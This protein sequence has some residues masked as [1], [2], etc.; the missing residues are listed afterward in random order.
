[1]DKLN[2]S[3]EQD[4][5][6]FAF[7][8][9]QRQ[10]E[11]WAKWLAHELEHYH[12]PVKLNGRK[13]LPNE[14]R[15]I[16][17][18]VDELSAGN[19]PEQIHDALRNSKNLIVIC[20]RKSAK[21]KWVNKEVEEFIKLGKTEHIF[22]FIIDGI[23]HSKNPKTECFPLALKQIPSDKERCG[24]NISESTSS[25]TNPRVCIDCP[26]DSNDKKHGDIK[27]KGRDAAV[28]KIVAGMLNL[29]FDT[30]WER[31]EKEKAEEE[32][33]IRE[34]RDNLLKLQSRFL[35]EKANDETASNR[36]F[37]SRL[38][39]IEALQKAY[40]R[41]AENALRRSFDSRQIKLSGH[42]RPVTNLVFSSDG[43]LLASA[44]EDQSIRIW[45]MKDG[46]CL[47][48]F[49]GHTNAIKS[50]N[51]NH[52]NKLLVSTSYDNTIR[53]WNLVTE[54]Q[55]YIFRKHCKDIQDAI[56]SPD[57]KEIICASGDSHIYVWEIRRRC[58]THVLNGHYS[59][60]SSLA[61]SPDG[62]NF[63]SISK[64]HICVWDSKT[65]SKKKGFENQY[66]QYSKI[67]YNHKGDKIMV[68]PYGQYPNTKYSSIVSLNYIKR[69]EGAK[70]IEI[71]DSINLEHVSRLN[72]DYASFSNDDKHIITSSNNRTIDFLDAKTYKRLKTI[73]SDYDFSIFSNS[74]NGNKIALGLLNGEITILDYI[75]DRSMLTY[76]AKDITGV[77][78]HSF[79]PVFIDPDSKYVIARIYNNIY[80]LNS[81][82]YN[83]EKIITTNDYVDL[84]TFCPKGKYVAFQSNNT[85]KIW[86]IDKS[87]IIKT[88]EGHTDYIKSISFNPDGNKLISASRDHTIRV[89]DIESG[90]C[91]KT[92]KSHLD[93]VNSASYSPNGRQIV[94]ASDDKTIRI[95][96]AKNY[97][98]ISVNENKEGVYFASFMTDGDNIISVSETISI[99]D[100]SLLR[101]TQEI[102][103]R[104]ISINKDCS[105]VAL[106][107]DNN[108]IMIYDISSGECVQTL[109]G[110]S[111]DID[112][113]IFSAD[114]RL[115]V[116]TSDD[117]MV[118]IWKYPTLTELTSLTR[119]NL[120]GITLS[121]EERS[122]YYLD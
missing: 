87:Q 118:K 40:T 53:I 34:Q 45:D 18:D 108:S 12:L 16:F 13:D 114:N 94:S 85:I 73:K 39:A 110:H 116:S 81:S 11:D 30:L 14:L 22:P 70:E 37:K 84:I 83:V 33:K 112:Q 8:S 48:I 57:D 90:R 96:D 100:R 27:D 93:S 105:L 20:S 28:V 78:H 64:D 44:S 47:M 122:K 15:P 95:W 55:T 80:I 38:L 115:I 76:A 109:L 119:E 103:G 51:F 92:I 91:I 56:F 4:K 32:R 74:S 24:A 62:T 41:E 3:M 77:E 104:F 88:L 26:L 6:Y 25:S 17:R 59:Y 35:A 29:K 5:E 101:K 67:S 82:S 102:S 42:T 99:W 50:I 97:K 31:Y 54:K 46:R 63:A 120:K 36:V 1:M 107:G 71:L 89:W 43:N 86:D 65:Y 79:W 60:V 111:D 68:L 121:P 19:L 2:F 66:H 58:C 75:E 49:N 7:I 113:V 61:C 106:K 69:T 10:D 21:S 23:A 117:G 98:C 9:Y 72:G 52:T